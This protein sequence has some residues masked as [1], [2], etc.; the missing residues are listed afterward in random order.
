MPPLQPH[1]LFGIWHVHWHTWPAARCQP[2]V[3]LVSRLCRQSPKRYAVQKETSYRK[4]FPF[5]MDVAM[6][7]MIMAGIEREQADEEPKQEATPVDKS[8]VGMLGYLLA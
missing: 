7:A 2:T 8:L 6:T 3:R 4:K 5:P 1:S